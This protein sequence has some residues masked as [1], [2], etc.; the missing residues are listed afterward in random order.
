[1][2]ILILNSL[3][4]GGIPFVI[5]GSIALLLY[6]QNDLS[7]AK[8]TFLVGLII[9]FVAAA[10]VIYDLDHWSI[11]KRSIIHLLTMLIT[12]YPILLFSGWFDITS[13]SDALIVLLIFL[14]VG[15]VLW[16]VFIILARIFAW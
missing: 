15:V 13:I 4:R 16:S 8:S 9:F 11:F 2:D 6:F 7:N 12:V 14:L 1:M 3:L 5:M 10:S